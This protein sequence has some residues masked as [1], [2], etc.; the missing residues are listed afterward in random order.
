MRLVTWCIRTKIHE[1]G[2]FLEFRTRDRGWH[3][4]VSTGRHRVDSV[5]IVADVRRV[6]DDRFGLERKLITFLIDI[7]LINL[8]VI[9]TA[10]KLPPY[11]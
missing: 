10:V 4:F 9:H 6:L 5:L 1:S 8:S 7:F 2:D 3:K 11:A